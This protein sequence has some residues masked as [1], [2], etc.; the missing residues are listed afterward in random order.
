VMLCK[1]RAYT[2]NR[3]WWAGGRVRFDDNT[4]TAALR[5]VSRRVLGSFS[6][7]VDVAALPAA[8]ANGD[9]FVIERGC[10]RTF[11]ACCERLNLENF[12]GFTTMPEQTVQR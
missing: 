7:A 1:V 11:N 10:P 8:P 2:L 6:G 9:T 3:N 5:G 4:A 12:G